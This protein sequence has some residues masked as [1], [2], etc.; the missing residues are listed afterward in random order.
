MYNFDKKTEYIKEL[1]TPAM[2]NYS[3]DRPER[4]S[5]SQLEQLSGS[6]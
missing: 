5:A 3:P 4:D 1:N 6:R 2:Q